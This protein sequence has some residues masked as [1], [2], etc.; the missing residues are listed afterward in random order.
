M[1]QYAITLFASYDPEDLEPPDPEHM[2]AHD[3][4]A[5]NGTVR[6]STPRATVVCSTPMVSKC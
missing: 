1:T 2:A 5:P 4:R 3:R 6:G